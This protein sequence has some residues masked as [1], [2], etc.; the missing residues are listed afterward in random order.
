MFVT[1]PSI[2]HAFNIDD[3]INKLSKSI[4][5]RVKVPICICLQT[6]I[7]RWFKR[8]N[9][10]ESKGYALPVSMERVGNGN[11]ISLH[12]ADNGKEKRERVAWA[13]MSLL[14]DKIYQ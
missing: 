7:S 14:C 10:R 6:I 11:D 2:F 12:V 5:C 4:S 1:L 9:R 13:M 8:R 3:V